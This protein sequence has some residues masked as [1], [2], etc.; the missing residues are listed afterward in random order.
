MWERVYRLLNG[1][2]SGVRSSGDV[3]GHGD[4]DAGDGVGGMCTCTCMWA[5]TTIGR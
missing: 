4:V 2:C 1:E 5:L 3:G